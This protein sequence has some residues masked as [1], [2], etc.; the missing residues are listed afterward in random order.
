MIDILTTSAASANALALPFDW[1]V[2]PASRAGNV[3]W[4]DYTNPCLAPGHFAEV[5]EVFAP[6]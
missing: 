3:A 4:H 2:V 6:R 1:S 5:L